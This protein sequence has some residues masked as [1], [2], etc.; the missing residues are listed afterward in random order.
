MNQKIIKH[1]SSRIPDVLVYRDWD[2][3]TSPIVIVRAFGTIDD[4]ANLSVSE[5][6]PMSNVDM[7]TDFIETFNEEMAAK[8]CQR[9]DVFNVMPK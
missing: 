6:Y 8:F 2:E 1:G 5:T 3:N 7:A 9:N 4:V